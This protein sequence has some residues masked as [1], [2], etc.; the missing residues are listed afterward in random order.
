MID[1]RKFNKGVPYKYGEPKKPYGLRLTDTAIIWLK[2]MGGADFIEW[3]ARAQHRFKL[4]EKIERH[5]KGKKEGN[6]DDE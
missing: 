3:A 2:K 6:R 4:F 1:K 5:Y